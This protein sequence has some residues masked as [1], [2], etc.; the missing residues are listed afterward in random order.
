MSCQRCAR[1]AWWRAQPGPM[2]AAS[3][4]AVLGCTRRTARRY[5]VTWE[6]EGAANVVKFGRHGRL[7]WA[8]K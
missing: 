6:R 7:I 4:A 8:P 3:V 1:L 2:T 5:L